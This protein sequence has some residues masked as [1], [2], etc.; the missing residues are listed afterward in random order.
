MS[1]EDAEDLASEVTAEYVKAELSLTGRIARFVG[2]NLDSDTWSKDRR[3]STGLVRRAIAASMGGMFTKGRKATA[4]VAKEAARRGV[5]AADEQLGSRATELGD[6]GGQPAEHGA[7][8][9]LADLKSV[10]DTMKDRSMTAYQRIITE[11]TQ[12]VDAGTATRKAAATRALSE[13]ADA[14]ITGFV[15]KAGRNWEIATYVE[16]AIRTHAANIM[17]EAHLGRLADAGV[18]LVIVSEAPYECDKCKPWEGKVLEVGGPSGKHL[19]KVQSGRT[20]LTAEVAGSLAEARTAGLFHANCRHSL[21]AYIPG[22]TRAPVKA[23]TKG[24]TYKDTQRQRAL[25]RLA[26]KWD[27]RRAAALDDDQR[28]NAEQHFKAARAKIREHVSRTGLPRK[29]NRE[30]HDTTR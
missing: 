29:T 27:R 24:V 16:M 25:E 26:R 3:N 8:A 4:K 13:F 22:A 17:I 12:A 10:D 15:D 7:K 9:M 19:V 18:K 30:R 14:G 21:E 5:A 23:D 11:V 28:A 6:P 2:L 20:K 1:P